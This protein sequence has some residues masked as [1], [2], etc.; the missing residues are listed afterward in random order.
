MNTP[1][2]TIDTDNAVIRFY[3]GRAAADGLTA[4]GIA[5]LQRDLAT[6]AQALEHLAGCR[7]AVE[8][9]R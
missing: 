3:A 1:Y 8:V 9:T 4:A 6:V 7:F 2:V 5:Q